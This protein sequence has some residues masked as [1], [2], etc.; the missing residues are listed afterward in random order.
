MKR[1]FVQKHTETGEI[2]YYTE[3]FEYG[4]WVYVRGSSRYDKSEA[5]N[6]YDSLGDGKIE[7][8]E[9]DEY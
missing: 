6:I 9:E 4:M 2:I 3:Y 7:V 1:R 8:L 5:K